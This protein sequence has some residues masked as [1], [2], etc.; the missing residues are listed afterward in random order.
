M[1]T[2][3]VI[4]PGFRP[5]DQKA[6]KQTGHMLG[7]L[8][9]HQRIPVVDIL[10]PDRKISCRSEQ[11]KL[12]T[13]VVSLP[14]Y[15]D[16]GL[17]PTN[18]T[19]EANIDN[20]PDRLEAVME[21][22]KLIMTLHNF[23]VDL[24]ILRPSEE[25]LSGVYTRDIAVTIGDKLIRANLKSPLRLSEEAS[26]EGGIKPPREV[27]LEG[28]NVFL[29]GCKNLVFVGVGDRTND[30][31]IDWL[32]GILGT[33]YEVKS[34]KLKAGVLHLDC[35]FSPIKA[36]GTSN[37][38]ALVYKAGFENEN[39]LRFLMSIYGTLFDVSKAEF[40]MLGPNTLALDENTRVVNPNCA[41]VISFLTENGQKVIPI[42]LDEIIKGGGYSRCSV[43]PLSRE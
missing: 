40:K 19:S 32:Q 30:E 20:K 37:G 28:G 2:Q 17:K 13:A 11:G 25:K 3:I 4:K 16:W 42:K 7:G 14:T 34:I 9:K 43:M 35:V 26:F 24:V 10:P 21:H 36:T 33:E 18:K 31:A 41:Q 6:I 27:L 38:A 29:E 15:L 5:P 23:G 39:D 12:K 22:K 8:Q 1:E